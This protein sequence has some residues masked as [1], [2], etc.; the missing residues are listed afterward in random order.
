MP[1]LQQLNEFRNS[2]RTI[3]NE[4]AVLASQNIPYENLPLP[5]SEPAS[6]PPSGVPAADAAAPAGADG[7]PDSSNQDSLEDFVPNDKPS[8]ELFSSGDLEGPPPADEPPDFGIMDDLAFN[9]FLNTLPDDLPPAP[10]PSL[11]VE[12]AAGMSAGIETEP[13][14][15]EEAA[16]EV[17]APP[18]DFSSGGDGGLTEPEGET[19]GFDDLFAD[20]DFGDEGAGEAGAYTDEFGEAPP[21]DGG[22]QAPTPE[23]PESDAKPPEAG[24]D[25]GTGDVPPGEDFPAPDFSPSNFDFPPDEEFSPPGGETNG[26]AG[27]AEKDAFDRFQ[28]EGSAAGFP[29]EAEVPESADRK[30]DGTADADMDGFSLSGIDDIL[31][32]ATPPKR[33]EDIVL[34]E[35]DL[36]KFQETLAGYPLNLRVACEEII[37][38]GKGPAE[39][40]DALIKLLV[41]GGTPRKAASLAGEILHKFIPIPK[42]FEKKTGESLEAEQGTF[43]YIFS[44]K[45][46]PVLRIF[47]AVALVS[48]SVAYLAWQFIVIPLYAGSIYRRGYERIAAGEYERANERFADAFAVHPVK[49]WF[50]QYAEAFRD[51]RQYLYAEGKYDEL[52]RYYPRDKKGALDY[53][54]METNYLRNYSKAD[55]II[56]TNILD[57]NV[58]DQEGLLAQGDNN[59]AWGEVDPSRYEDARQAY[60]R[61]LERYG[62]QDPIVERMLLYFIRTDNLG[63]VI[64]LQQ[65]LT[66]NSKKRHA[67]PAIL[68]ELGGYLL[69]KQIEVVRGVPDEHIE[70]IEGVRD[71]LIKANQGD[72]SLPEPQYHLARY[73]NRFGSTEEE[74]KALESAVRAF[75]A[76]REESPRRTA[77]R[78]DA[79]RRFAQVLVNA[80]EFFPAEERLINGINVYEDALNRRLLSRSPEYGRLYADLGDI[81]YFTKSWDMNQA[82][83]YYRQAELNG[84]APPE[85]QY[86]MGAAHYLLREWENALDRFFNAS[87]ELTLNRRLLHALGNVSYLRGNYFA[88]QGYYRRLLDLLEAERARFPMLVPN[89]RLDHL[90]LAERLMV[91][92]NNMAVTLEALSNRTGDPQ[93]QAGAVAQYSESAR[94]W[95]ALTRD[96]NTMVR[97]AG[98]N[99]GF[100]NSQNI[101]HPQTSYE[102]Q[103]F[104]QIDKDVL[105]PSSWELL[106]PPDYRI[107]D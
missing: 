101:L 90:E 85:M 76:A 26:P 59:L 47:L 92:R 36:A 73:Y 19:A 45:V 10:D 96:P 20:I 4:P 27:S 67:S 61:L 13:P 25:A 32:T 49:S 70:R 89:E 24:V 21:V 23:E 64:P 1:S 79:D 105:E 14:R 71:I 65:Y 35:E 78:I 11:P 42:S 17:Q 56:R 8:G 22:F 3:G 46:L 82:L 86:R 34:S 102:P 103:L 41:K 29:P 68:S 107:S 2:F 43:S 7:F 63:E 37:A 97:S 74:R 33:I 81:E 75:D 51:E 66:D 88:A 15:A 52:L 28:F 50:Y 80:R 84:W 60:A 40:V 48:A 91:A 18:E 44:R 39:Q 98:T 38:E 30:P 94:A 57:Y 6:P 58:N 16:D 5:K 31:T 55:R 104:N 95:D 9:D 77:Y 99:L 72:P 53:A 62:W 83:E 106:A 12:S 93:Y 54:A 69:D 87:S 100:L